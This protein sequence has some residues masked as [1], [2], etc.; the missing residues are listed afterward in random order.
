MARCCAVYRAHVTRF[1]ARARC[2]VWPDG[3]RRPVAAVAGAAAQDWPQWRGPGSAAISTEAPLPTTWS[4]T[5]HLAW[6]AAL[7]GAGTSSP[8][9]VGD[10]VIVTSQVGRAPV[11]GGR[12]PAPAR[13]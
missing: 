4:A 2:V 1:P 11:A 7:A 3:G 12:Q 6:R 8:I 13:A 5:E 9:V 10:R